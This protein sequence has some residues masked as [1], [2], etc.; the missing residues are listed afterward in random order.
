MKRILVGLALLAAAGCDLP[1]GGATRVVEVESAFT[2]REDQRAFAR[3][4]DFSVEFVDVP[5]DE[6]CPVEV[7]CAIAGNAVV[8]VRLSYRNGEPQMFELQTIHATPR[9]SLG[10]YAV[11]LLEL[12]PPRS[13]REPDPDYRVRLRI[14]PVFTI[15]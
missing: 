13:E 7:Y 2:L 10:N 9:A 12:Q 15:D 3:G 8:R 6:R 5:V 4:T 1:T 14:D 11:Q